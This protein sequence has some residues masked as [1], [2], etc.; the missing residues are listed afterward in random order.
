MQS[1]FGDWIVNHMI[2]IK[3]DNNDHCSTKRYVFGVK[4]ILLGGFNGVAA[5]VVQLLSW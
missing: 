5:T 1:K 2:T 3:L 4:L